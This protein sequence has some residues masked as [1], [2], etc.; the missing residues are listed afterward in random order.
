MRVFH[1]HDLQISY[2]FI[3][4]VWY[5]LRT[6]LIAIGH[7]MVG[8][9]TVLITLIILR[10]ESKLAFPIAFLAGGFALLPD[11]FW[12]R[13]IPKTYHSLLFSIHNSQ[14]SNLFFF[15]RYLDILYR[16]D[17]PDNAVIYIII[18]FILTAIY[19]LYTKKEKSARL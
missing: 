7:F 19:S 10:Y 16:D 11:I 9:S 3:M 12:L 2:Y 1:T 17:I 13:S 5:W 6:G 8:Y 14:Y 15:H 18:A 4:F